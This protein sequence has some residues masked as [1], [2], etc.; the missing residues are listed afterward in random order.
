[1]TAS[2][3]L[4]VCSPALLFNFQHL[5]H[6]NASPEERQITL[7]VK[8][9]RGCSSAPS[10][11]DEHATAQQLA[12]VAGSFGSIWF[13]AARRDWQRSERS[14][15]VAQN[16][17]KRCDNCFPR[18]SNACLAG[19]ESSAQHKCWKE[20][21]CGGSKI[22]S[23]GWNQPVNFS[24]FRTNTSI[25]T[26]WDPVSTSTIRLIK[27][28][29]AR[30][31]PGSLRSNKLHNKWIPAS[32]RVSEEPGW[33]K[34]THTSAVSLSTDTQTCSFHGRLNHRCSNVSR[35]GT[36]LSKKGGRPEMS[37]TRQ[38]TADTRKHRR[39]AE[40]PPHA[41]GI[42][43]CSPAYHAFKQC[44]ICKTKRFRNTD[45]GSVPAGRGGAEKSHITQKNNPQC[46]QHIG[47]RLGAA[48]KTKTVLTNWALFIHI[49]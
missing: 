36:P 11:S 23:H 17:T 44:F 43:G 46:L 34:H 38:N 19:W 5:R 26:R 14:P 6:S 28:P 33:H 32:E 18:H 2:P 22:A 9:P 27:L 16:K 15:T 20:A 25:N 7:Q 47:R 48:N 13:G 1:M 42:F 41:S 4:N 30:K 49:Y 12:V 37:P 21:Q 39:R 40:S 29:G 35:V 31:A 24:Y 3:Q 8:K 10:G 45:G